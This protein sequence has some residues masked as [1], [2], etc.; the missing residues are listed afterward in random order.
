MRVLVTGGSGFIGSWIIRRLLARGIDIRVLDL[1]DDRRLLRQLT[2]DED[3]GGAE[4]LDWRIGDVQDFSSVEAAVDGCDHVL[5]LAALL[6]NTCSTEPLRGVRINLGGT[7]NVFESARLHGLGGVTYMS[8]AGVFGPASATVP[9]PTTHYGAFKLACEGSARAYWEDHGL[10][11]V[12]FRPTSV[13][14]PGREVGLSA[15]PTLACRAAVRGEAYVI[16][17]TGTVDLLYV[18]DVAAVFEAALLAPPKGAH[19]FNLL[20]DVTE[21]Q[22]LMAAIGSQVPGAALSAKGPVLPIHPRIAPDDFGRHFGDLG[23]TPLATGIARTIAYYRGGASWR[24]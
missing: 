10:N 2:G 23:R 6:A 16:P 5:H 12:G 18:D 14:G 8:T 1:V 9:L 7:L 24:G 21:V 22:D 13:Y 19:A 11:S 4:T 17:F 3:G 20:G 15:G